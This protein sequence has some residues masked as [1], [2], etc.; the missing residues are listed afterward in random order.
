[1]PPMLVPRVTAQPGA[2]PDLSAPSVAPV[3]NAAPQQIEQLGEAL[4]RAGSAAFQTGQTIANK[5]QEMTD[6]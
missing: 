6:A 1:M 5:V 2:T 4:T 3:R